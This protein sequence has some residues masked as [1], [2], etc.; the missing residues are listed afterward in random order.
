MLIWDKYIQD[1]FKS[2][3]LWLFLC[4]SYG[5]DDKAY[6]MVK[7]LTIDYELS[8]NAFNDGNNHLSVFLNEN[9]IACFLWRHLYVTPMNWYNSYFTVRWLGHKPMGNF[10]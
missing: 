9:F 10:F 8:K 6:N 4:L 1:Y 7:N 5:D 3:K 2:I